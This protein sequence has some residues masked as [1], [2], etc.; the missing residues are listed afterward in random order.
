MELSFFQIDA[1][2]DKPF[3]GNPAAV[4]PLKEWLPDEMMQKIASEMNLSETA[5]FVP[6]SDRHYHLRWFT[7]TIEARLCGHATLSS[8]LALR[9]IFEIDGRLRF[10]TQSGPL[11]VEYKDKKYALDMPKAEQRMAS[12]LLPQI[13]GCFNI[14]PV[15]FF[16]GEENDMAIF[17]KADDVRS[18]IPDFTK[19][20][21]SKKDIIVTAPGTDCDFVSRY[22]APLSGIPEDPVTG[23]THC[24]L[25]PY[26]ETRL[27]KQAFY[28]RQLSKRGGELWCH[29][30]GDRVIVAGQGVC[31]MNGLLHL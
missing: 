4:V 16:L 25:V 21:E 12:E 13:R 2:T 31:V 26:W 14:E 8:A 1:F 10:E 28:A 7:P 20:E 30:A 18:L 23:S 29:L 22:F 5:F 24:Q 6:L 17:E 11:F 15:A 9:E 19:I 27:G 3:T